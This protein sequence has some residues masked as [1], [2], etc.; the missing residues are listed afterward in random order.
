VK[1]RLGLLAGA[2]ALIALAAFVWLHS[3]G[4]ADA[5]CER[6]RFVP[7]SGFSAWP[8]GARCSYGEP[9]RTDVVLNGWFAAVAGVLALGLLFAR[10]AL[11]RPG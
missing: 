10:A 1:V 9:V 8:P 2:W 4:P 3:G 5:A 6:S 11:R 7:S